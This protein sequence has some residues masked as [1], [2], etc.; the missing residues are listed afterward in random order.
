[1]TGEITVVAGSYIEDASM[2]TLLTDLIS[3]G[4]GEAADKLA[5]EYLSE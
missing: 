2:A 3:Y 5:E 1:V 4:F